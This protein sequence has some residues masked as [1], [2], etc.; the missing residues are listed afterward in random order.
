MKKICILI[1]SAIL[2]FGLHAQSSSVL[3]LEDFSEDMKDASITT[4]TTNSITGEALNLQYNSVDLQNTDLLYAVNS[5]GLGADSITVSYDVS[6]ATETGGFDYEAGSILYVDYVAVPL[7]FGDKTYNYELYLRGLDL[8]VV[9]LKFYENSVSVIK[10]FSSPIPSS[11]SLMDF[12]FAPTYVLDDFSAPT[13]LELADMACPIYFLNPIEILICKDQL[14]A[15]APTIQNAI[16]VDNILVMAHKVTGIENE[17]SVLKT[18]IKAFNLL[19]K[20]VS[21]ETKNEAIIVIYSDGSSAR[22]YN[23]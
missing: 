12:G 23:K 1:S 4:N 20:E 11:L 8:N 17:T 18:P 15:N 9:D 21:L 16:R 22:E 5:S 7:S 6:Y 3:L 2:S 19:G 13:P 10:G 14:V